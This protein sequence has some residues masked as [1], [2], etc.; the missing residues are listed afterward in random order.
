MLEAC[1]V[2]YKYSPRLLILLLVDSSIIT[3]ARQRDRNFWAVTPSGKDNSLKFAS[4]GWRIPNYIDFRQFWHRF[5]HP[6]E[7]DE[8][9]VV[10]MIAV[11]HSPAKIREYRDI[12]MCGAAGM[13]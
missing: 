1:V 13:V 8:Q 9:V 4:C 6:L 2:P 5:F 10:G 7:I 11:A 12:G 3:I